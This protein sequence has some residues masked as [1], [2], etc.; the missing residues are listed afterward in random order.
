VVSVGILDYNV[1]NLH[2]V[3]RAFSLRGDKVKL[4]SD[5]REI[6]NFS[7]L[8]LPGVGAFGG[9]MS[10]IHEK[11]FVHEILKFAKSGRPI[12]GICLGMQLLASSG[13]EGGT[14]EGLNLI[15]GSVHPL[16]RTQSLRR[17]PN[18][19]WRDVEVLCRNSLT[20]EE[21]HLRT[22]FAHSYE[23]LPQDLSVIVARSLIHTTSIAAVINLDN[24]WGFQFHP[25]KS[26]QAGLNL[27]LRFLEFS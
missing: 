19:G 20:N 7:H 16:R 6:R 14:H 21:R 25:E 11:S 24:V 18:I 4:M 12:L 9:A 13:L 1:G 10:V 5:S 15:A 2:S 26:G 22:C 3:A 17:V 27:I 8:I 23:F